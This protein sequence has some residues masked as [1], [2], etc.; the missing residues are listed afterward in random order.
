MALMVLKLTVKPQGNH[1]GSGNGDGHVDMLIT[2]SEA[3]TQQNVVQIAIHLIYGKNQRLEVKR[4]PVDLQTD[5]PDKPRSRLQRYLITKKE[6]IWLKSQ[7]IHD[8]HKIN[9]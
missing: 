8:E 5:A 2:A 7:R 6:K 4:L 1:S 9:A 3:S